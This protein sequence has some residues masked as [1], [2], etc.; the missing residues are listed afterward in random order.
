MHDLVALNALGGSV[1][2]ID[3]FDGVTIRE[4]PD[5]AYA[6]MAIRQNKD[7]AFLRAIK[8]MTGIAPPIQGQSVTTK[9]GK[10]ALTIFWIGQDQWMVEAPFSSHENI[11]ADMVVALGA[12]ASVTEQ[13]DAWARFDLDGPGSVSM[14]E[15]LSAT[16]SAGMTAGAATRT[17]IEHLGCFLICRKPSRNF[18]ILCPRSS[19]SSMHHALVSIAKSCL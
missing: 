14:L 11:A 9:S 7:A 10:V 19:A 3:E 1:A 12:T 18:S 8:K 17:S 5:V 2:Q 6:S 15:R 13:N 4:V 16:D